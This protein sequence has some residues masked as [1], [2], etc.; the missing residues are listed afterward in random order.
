MDNKRKT[1][2]ADTQALSKR[3]EEIIGKS[4][5][6]II[7]EGHYVVD[8]APK[9]YTNLVF[10]LRRDPHELKDILEKRGY[11]EN[12]INENLAAEILDVCLMDAISEYGTKNICEFDVS[13]RTVEEVVDEIFLVIKDKKRCKIGTVDWLSKLENDGQL[14][15]FLRDF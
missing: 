14:E 6:T 10:V 1:L 2:I 5:G 13:N 15:M 3:L 9:K 8:V 7:V 12:K 11:S 4:H